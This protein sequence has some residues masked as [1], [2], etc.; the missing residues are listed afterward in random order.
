MSVTVFPSKL[1]ADTPVLSWDF[2]STIYSADI[3]IA[4]SSG[5]DGGGMDT[6]LLT[7]TISG[8]L[9]RVPVQGGTAGVVYEITVSAQIT[10]VDGPIVQQVGK[11]AVLPI[12]PFQAS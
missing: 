6:M 11:L 3:V 2:Q 4:V 9:I 8:S 12:N 7:P 10:S 1:S 5:T